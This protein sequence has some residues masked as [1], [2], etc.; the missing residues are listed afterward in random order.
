MCDRRC[1]KRKAILLYIGVRVHHG[2]SSCA[3]IFA[4]IERNGRRRHLAPAGIETAP[5]NMC[6]GATHHAVCICL[7]EIE[8]G[9]QHRM[10]AA[11]TN[12]LRIHGACLRRIFI[13]ALSCIAS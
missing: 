1:M 13:A 2:S 10:P 12:A 4:L 6:G 5:N 11:L 7:C 9:R 3:E 8:S